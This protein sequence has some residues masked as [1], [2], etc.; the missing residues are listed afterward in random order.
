MEE[1]LKNNL[2]K[3]IES[4]EI[5]RLKYSSHQIIKLIAVSKYASLEQIIALYNVGH[6]A[7]GENKVQ[8]L[9]TKSTQVNNLPIEWHMIGTLQE[10]KI[11]H[12]LE[13][14]PF[15]FQALDSIKLATALQKRL[16]NN[17]QFLNCLLQLNSSKE[18]SKSGFDIEIAVESYKEIVESCPNI[19]LKGV[20]SIGANTAD[21]KLIDSCFKKVRDIFDNLQSCGAEIMSCG[22]SNDYKIA[23]ANGANM[24]RIGS[25]IFNG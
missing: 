5:E 21:T 14:K 12:L 2:T 23:I 13:I 4:I 24:L 19:K 11:N 18:D 25:N 16:E 1:S 9:K 22:M 6:R 10:N 3:L 7:F 20:M 15:L 17:N 8:D